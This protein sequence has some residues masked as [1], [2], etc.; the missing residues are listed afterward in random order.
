MGELIQASCV[1]CG[2]SWDRKTGY[3]LTH[4]REENLIREFPI[5]MNTLVRDLLENE[6]ASYFSFREA[7]CEACHNCVSVPVLS[8]GDKGEVLA[9]G[10][11]PVCGSKKV[12][13]PSDNGILCPRC[14]KADLELTWKGHWD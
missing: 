11:C 5:G 13:L 2:S 10:T 9:M 14:R 1:N 12:E 7:V 6:E 8:K 3:G 4:G